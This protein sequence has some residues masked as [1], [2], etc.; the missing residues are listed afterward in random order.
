MENFEGKAMK[1]F[2]EGNIPKYRMISAFKFFKS[3]LNKLKE[4]DLPIPNW[5]FRKMHMQTVFNV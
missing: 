2:N 5:L 4:G 3:T 1:S